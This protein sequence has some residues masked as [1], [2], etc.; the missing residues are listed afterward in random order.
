MS[1]AEDLQKDHPVLAVLDVIKKPA[2][3]LDDAFNASRG[4]LSA[5]TIR[6]VGPAIIV[7]LMFFIHFM[8][9]YHGYLDAWAAYENEQEKQR[10]TKFF[11]ALMTTLIATAG[12]GLSIVYALSVAGAVTVATSLVVLLPI[13]LPAMLGVIYTLALG[14]KS[15]VLHQIKKEEAIAREEYLAYI[16]DKECYRGVAQDYLK[17]YQDLHT[18][19]LN[20]EKDVAMGTVEVFASVIIV[21]GIMLS[22]LSSG[23]LPLA[24]LITGV[25][26]GTMGKVYEYFDTKY[27]GAL[28]NRLR[29]WFGI[30]VEPPELQEVPV[31]VKIRKTSLVDGFKVPSPEREVK[32]PDNKPLKYFREKCAIDKQKKAEYNPLQV[33]SIFA[34]QKNAPKKDHQEASL[35]PNMVR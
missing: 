16:R 1:S 18:E 4:A 29:N 24:L 9:A 15:Y 23:A 21:T 33:K 6:S 31:H 3:V 26:V 8:E 35:T 12:V 19:R 13:V 7:P 22:I 25:V 11:V 14:R 27:E 20:A 28:S 2:D 32:E 10:K 34:K 17:K 5:S 30:G